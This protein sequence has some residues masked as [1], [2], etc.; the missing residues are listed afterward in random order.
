[1]ESL[2]TMNVRVSHSDAI[3]EASFRNCLNGNMD[4]IR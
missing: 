3:E 4:S 2:E 1:M